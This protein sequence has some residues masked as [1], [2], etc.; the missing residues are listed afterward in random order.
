[1]IDDPTE[2]AELAPLDLSNV[3]DQLKATIQHAFIQAIPP[4]TWQKMIQDEI[5]KFTVDQTTTT[6][7][8]G[9]DTVKVTPAKFGVMAQSILADVMRKQFEAKLEQ[10][11]FF[12]D[13]KRV[14]DIMIEW[15]EEHR[16]SLV[17]EFIKRVTEAIT[18]SMHG[19]I[20]SNV[21]TEVNKFAGQ[22]PD[23]NNPGYNMNGDYTG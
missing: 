14:Q 6:R 23:P 10:E 11:D 2:K 18:G 4:E 20:I 22:K 13:G 15:L 1:M 16:S 3:A 8:Y 12:P 19:L 17:F 7:S 9:S 5:E 21:W